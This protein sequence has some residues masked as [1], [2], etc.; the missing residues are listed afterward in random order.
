LQLD[1]VVPETPNLGAVDCLCL[2]QSY[3][4]RSTAVDVLLVPQ[5]I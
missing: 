5:Q 4:R 3:R 2:L 1:T